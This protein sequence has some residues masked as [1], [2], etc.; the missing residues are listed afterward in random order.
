VTSIT[1]NSPGTVFQRPFP[2]GDPEIAGFDGDT[3][4]DA[5][6]PQ[7]ANPTNGP[8]SAAVSTRRDC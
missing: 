8:A 3:P 5:Y 2:T 4:I 6:A 7:Q 1:I